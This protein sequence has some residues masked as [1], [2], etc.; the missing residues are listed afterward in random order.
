MPT[1]KIVSESEGKMKKGI[2]ALHHALKAI[3]TGRAST[4]LVEHLMVEYYGTMTPLKQIATLSTPQ[5]DSI[6]IKPF[7][8]GALKDIE[9]AIKSSD[10]SIATLTEGK[11]IRLVIPPLSKERRLQLITQVK[12]HAEQAKVGIR[13]VRRDAI[14]DLEKE[15][16][17]GLITEDDRDHGKKLIE[18][19]TKKYTTEIDNIVKE[20]SDEIMK[21]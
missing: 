14:K 12:H 18:D 20:K 17:D 2:E 10:L 15:Q 9:K 5:A 1:A 19:A 11:M 3:R 16:K 13:N 7:D 21:D 8:V 4:G 6:L